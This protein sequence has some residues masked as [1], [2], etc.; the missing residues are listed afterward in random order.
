MMFRTFSRSNGQNNWQKSDAYLNWSRA[1][2]LSVL[3]SSIVNSR[4]PALPRRA[5]SG[6]LPILMRHRS[7]SGLIPS[8]VATSLVV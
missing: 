6:Y 5:A 4:R 8:T 1:V 3:M 2:A 7:K